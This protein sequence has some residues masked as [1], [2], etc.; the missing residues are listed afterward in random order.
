MKGQRAVLV[1]FA[2]LAALG[3]VAARAE[4]VDTGQ[5]VPEATLKTV[6]GGSGPLVE[7]GSA[8]TAILF[9]R[10]E[11]ER[12]LD[13]L[14]TMAQCQPQLAGKPVRWVGVVPG[15]TVPADAKAAV[16]ASRMKLPVL[17][18]AGDAIY[19][20]LGVRMH[21]GIAIVDR[22]RR[23]V[24]YEPYHQVDYCGI[25]VA[26]VRRA[27]GE[28]SEA[29]VAKAVEPAKS[30]LPGDDPT[31]VARRNVSFGR[32]LL[33]A[34]AFA[35]AHESARKAIL[36]A[37]LAAAWT[38]EGE[39]FAAEGKCPDAL[40]AFDRA[41]VLDPNDAAASSGKQACTR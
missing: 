18:D 4:A 15:D 27:L 5:L 21:P 6:D 36:T 11:Q 16:V 1:P 40:K 38:L 24:A 14:R 10:A 37:P 29:E 23:L 33:G 2:V 7:R 12:S 31:G 8:A 26:R 17:V 28:I 19:A 30:A 13:T 20:A 25:V 34:K 9:F 22:A 39:V 41:L 32:K 35:A 3:A